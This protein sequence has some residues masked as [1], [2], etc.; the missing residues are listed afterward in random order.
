MT[1]EP[2]G[3][4]K[5]DTAAPPDP[6]VVNSSA[7]L[8]TTANGRSSDA[9]EPK[10]PKAEKYDPH[11]TDN[12]INATGPKASPRFRTVI[13]SLTRHLH[14]FCRENEVT[15]EE[16]MGA[17]DFLN[18]SGQMST[19]RRNETQL[20]S[21]ILGIESLVDEITYTLAS[22][23][24]NQ[25]TATAI[26]GPFWRKDAPLR[27]MGDSIV[28]SHIP[29]GEHTWLHGRVL[30]LTTSEPIAN[31]ELDVWHTAPNGLYEQQDAEQP[32]MNLRGRFVTGADGYFEFTC[33]RPTSYP[34]PYDGPAGE[35]LQK[36]DRH[37]M[38]PAHV[39]F[40][41]S[42][43]GYKPLVTQ[44]FDRRDEKIGDDAVFAVKDSLV[45]DFVP[46]GEEARR[47]GRT[48]QF[49]LEYDFRLVSFEEAKANGMA[50]L[51]QESVGAVG[52]VS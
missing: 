39:H 15:V 1:Q 49:E 47:K 2:N 30:D 23:A 17:V 20:V 31:A 8:P 7:N 19:D 10:E 40:I 5:N 45:V 21:D 12:V 29:N 4:S 52:A 48:E 34:I 44:V 11:F 51:Q 3:T 13:G 32:D 37:P 22:D 35:L 6:L 9:S 43:E 46:I 38:R 50:G 33:L 28:R 26:L 14:D 24:P 41:V 42:A 18:R 36:L 16:W 27:S 25:P